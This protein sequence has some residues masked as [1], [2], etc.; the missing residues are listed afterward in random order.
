MEG[1]SAD[2]DADADRVQLDLLRRSSPERRLALAL[3]LSSSV[4]GLSRRGLARV[5]PDASEQQLA[6]RWV[7]LSYGDELARELE[8]FLRRRAS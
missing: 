1:R 8:G 5:D 6:V 4:V 3:S 2:T 7:R